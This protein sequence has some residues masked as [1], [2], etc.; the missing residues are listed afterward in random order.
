[1]IEAAFPGDRV[2]LNRMRRVEFAMRIL[3][4]T[5]PALAVLSVVL[6]CVRGAQTSRRETSPTLSNEARSSV[7]VP[8][9]GRAMADFT[10]D[11]HPDIA[12]VEL[13]GFDSPTA[14]YS[15]EIRL[16][17]GGRQSLRLAAP[18]GGLQITPKDVTGDGNLDL[19]VRAARSRAPVAVFLNDG[20]GHFSR[21]ALSMF[22][23]ALRDLPSEL[24]PSASRLYS[25]ATL[26]SSEP[27]SIACRNTS[28]RDPRTQEGSVLSSSFGVPLY[29]FLPFGSSRAPP[30]IA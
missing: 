25:I 4:K 9:L 17:E 14:E 13:N 29:L 7:S 8:A 19:I 10:G 5:P 28:I 11:S 22:A 18:F 12:T 3:R 21:A 1:M 30:A 24:G 27:Y 2:L 23:Q 6:L 26:I 16:S 15:I 20:R